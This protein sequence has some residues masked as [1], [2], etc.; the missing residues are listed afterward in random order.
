[1]DLDLHAP[2]KITRQE[3]N[4]SKSLQELRLTITAGQEQE[5]F[6]RGQKISTAPRDVAVLVNTPL[7]PIKSMALTLRASDQTKVTYCAAVL[8]T[9]QG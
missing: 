6:L 1:M 2:C 9:G 3:L 5:E 4:T 7:G 8:C